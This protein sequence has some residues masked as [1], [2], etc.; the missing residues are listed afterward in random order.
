MGSAQNQFYPDKNHLLDNGTVLI[1]ITEIR[2]TVM[3]K[4]VLNRAKSEFLAGQN[5][6]LSKQV[7]KCDKLR[8]NRFSGSIKGKTEGKQE[9]NES[10]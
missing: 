1:M 3:A 4:Y 8:K 6:L 5:S 9:K 2:T 10:E 7:K